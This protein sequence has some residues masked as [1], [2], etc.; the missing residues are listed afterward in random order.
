NLYAIAD[1]PAAPQG[2][3]TRSCTKIKSG[4]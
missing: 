1:W 3:M 2:I 4:K